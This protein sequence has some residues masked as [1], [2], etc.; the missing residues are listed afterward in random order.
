V[1]EVTEVLH[2]EV[3]VHHKHD[4]EQV[5]QVE[6]QQVEVEVTEVQTLIVEH[7]LVHIVT[8]VEMLQQVEQVHETQHEEDEVQVDNHDLFEER[9]YFMLYHMQVLVQ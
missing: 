3:V 6:R 9:L 4:H 7:E 5:M 8:M 2:D 1:L